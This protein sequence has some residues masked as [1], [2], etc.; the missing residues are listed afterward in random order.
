MRVAL[1]VVA[2]PLGGPRTYGIALARALARRDDLDLTVLT[3]RPEAFPG[4]RSVKLPRMRPLADHVVAPT[5]LQRLKPD[6]YHNTK[7]ALPFVVPCPTVVTVHDLAYHHFPETFS[8]AARIYL[9]AH[10]VHAVRRASR[11]VAVSEHA[12]RD[13]IETLKVP[14][15]KVAVAHNGVAASFRDAPVPEP[16]ADLPRPYVL[17]VG[18]I[19]ARKNLDVLVDAI[20][21]VRTRYGLEVELAIAGRRGWRTEAFDRALERTPVRLLGVVDDADLPGLYAH[22]AAFVQPSSYEGFGLTAAEAMVMGAP[23]IAAEA[24]SLPEVV[25]DCALLVP[26]RDAQAL[27]GALSRL[28]EDPQQARELAEAGRARAQRFTWEA[29]AEAHVA[30]YR[31]VAGR[32]AA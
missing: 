21:L 3:D 16:R 9:R 6:V 19:Q 15:H 32:V 25:G 5:V 20:D 18:T 17:S 22:A 12:R 23:V 26:P 27:A 11:V 1:H 28:L 31:E 30:V 14:E 8:R 13:L 24:G 10:T 4:I 7:N 29:S 2:G